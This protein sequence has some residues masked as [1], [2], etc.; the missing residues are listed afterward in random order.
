MNGRLERVEQFLPSLPTREEIK[1]AIREANDALLT[2]FQILT[3][4]IR[5]M[6][7]LSAEGQAVLRRDVDDIRVEFRAAAVGRPR[8]TPRLADFLT[9]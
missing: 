9:S 1:T 2:K 5:D 3:G 7:R 6:V 8:P 4:D